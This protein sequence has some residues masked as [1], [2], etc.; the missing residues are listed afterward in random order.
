MDER[1]L[2]RLRQVRLVGRLLLHR[3]FRDAL[4]PLREDGSRPFIVGLP[5]DTLGQIAARVDALG[6]DAHLMVMT[7]THAPGARRV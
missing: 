7:H 3:S 6:G 5:E 2:E 4:R 1:E